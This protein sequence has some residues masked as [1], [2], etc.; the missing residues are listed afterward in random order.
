MNYYIGNIPFDAN[1][2]E[3]HGILGMKWGQR[4]GPPYPLDAQ[5]HSAAEKKAGWR[6]SLVGSQKTP[7]IKKKQTSY[8][9]VANKQNSNRKK[10]TDEQKAKIKKYVKYGA[11]AVAGCLAVYASVKIYQGHVMNKIAQ[12]EFEAKMAAGRKLLDEHKFYQF[13]FSEFPNLNK[14]VE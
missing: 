6:K 11:I 9:K 13:T 8:V 7:T 5:D 4:N 12:A 14:K 1:Y 10:L 2:L 3:H